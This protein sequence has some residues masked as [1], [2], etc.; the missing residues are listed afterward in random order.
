MK[1]FFN[2][3]VL[4]AAALALTLA[5]AGMTYAWFTQNPLDIQAAVGV[6]T[7]IVDFDDVNLNYYWTY[8]GDS[9]AG[10]FSLSGSNLL[11]DMIGGR[12]VP[13]SD[14]WITISTEISVDGW[15]DEV[16]DKPLDNSYKFPPALTALLGSDITSFSAEVID[17]AEPWLC[18]VW[19]DLD[20]YLLKYGDEWDEDMPLPDEFYISLSTNTKFELE[21]SVASME[22]GI[23]YTNVW[24]AAEIQA[25]DTTS[26]P[27]TQVVDGA[28]LYYCG[29][30]LQTWNPGLMF[31]D[32]GAPPAPPSG[33]GGGGGAA[34]WWTS[35]T[36]KEVLYKIFNLD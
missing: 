23:K 3:K 16:T 10:Q 1:K 25:L 5:L 34:E 18:A 20:A 11:G 17:P 24:K 7:L 33:G 27:I 29:I 28:V 21:G 14:A 13:R 4:V 19:Y 2:K 22:D 12:F 9:Y 32:G 36:P 15:W 31:I 6:K 8:P 30:D 35:L 26:T